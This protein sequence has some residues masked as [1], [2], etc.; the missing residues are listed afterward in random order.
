MSVAFEVVLQAKE[1]LKKDALLR[2]AGEG[3]M[4]GIME[5]W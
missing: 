2:S 4:G 3:I 1:T 5:C